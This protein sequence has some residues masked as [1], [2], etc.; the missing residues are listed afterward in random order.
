MSDFSV[1][2]ILILVNHCMMPKLSKRKEELEE[3]PEYEVR[4]NNLDHNI[5]LLF[6]SL[7]ESKLE[8]EITVVA[9]LKILY[10]EL[11]FD[12]PWNN[13]RCKEYATKLNGTFEMLYGVSLDRL[14][15]STFDSQAVFYACLRIL[16]NKLN[17]DDFKY[18]PSL[19]EAYSVIIQCSKVNST[20]IKLLI[21]IM[22]C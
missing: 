3:H 9:S 13:D 14:F 2:K 5:N 8:E 1:D 22:I 17:A 15:S 10:E 7:S 12:G 20:S 18:Y 6:H 19:I 11:K 21:N 16:H 4:L